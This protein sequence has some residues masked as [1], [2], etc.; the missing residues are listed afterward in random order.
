[1]VHI[2]ACNIELTR[3]SAK[4][5]LPGGWHEEATN[6]KSIAQLLDD[7]T[8]VANVRHGVV[9]EAYAQVQQS[10]LVTVIKLLAIN[11]K[12]VS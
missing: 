4:H 5:T 10:V 11:Y 8:K 12:F 1:M 9:Q 2:A 6:S 3:Q 7:A